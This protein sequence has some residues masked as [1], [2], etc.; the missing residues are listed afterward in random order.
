MPRVERD[1]KQYNPTPYKE[2]SREGKQ[3]SMNA[4]SSKQ[5]ETTDPYKIQHEK[6]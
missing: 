1:K 3:I 2:Q 4:N 5:K 6:K